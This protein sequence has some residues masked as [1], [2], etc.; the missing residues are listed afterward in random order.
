MRKNNRNHI[1]YYL[2]SF[3]VVLY[4]LH[5]TIT[6]AAPVEEA[7]PPIQRGLI[8]IESDGIDRELFREV[9]SYHGARP[10]KSDN[11]G[12]LKSAY[13]TTWSV[14]VPEKY[15]MD[16]PYGVIVYISSSDSGEIPHQW[17]P[18][19]DRHN[20]IW[21]GPNHAGNRVYPK[22]NTL[23][24]HALA[25][26]SLMQ[27]KERYHIDDERIY[28]SGRSGGG[29]IASYVAI[30]NSDLFSGGYY[31]VGCNPFRPIEVAAEVY[32]PGFKK[33]PTGTQLFR[34]LQDRYVMLTGSKDFNRE[35]TRAVYDFYLDE[36]FR[37][38]TYLD[39]PGMGH[40]QPPV[41]WFEKGII[42]LD[43]PLTI[44]TQKG[45]NQAVSMEER[46]QL[47][48]ALAGFKKATQCRV[49]D[50]E[51]IKLAEDKVAHLREE[52]AKAVIA[53]ELAIDSGDRSRAKSLLNKFKKS[54]KGV[55]EED[56]KRLTV[57]LTE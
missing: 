31:I 54:W 14:Y 50:D 53:I 57:R 25:L 6:D 18:I 19:F 20:L 52:Y 47:G 33:E 45:F 38:V 21:I 13:G 40:G 26:E 32:M 42:A 56:I 2:G 7:S 8:K 10:P 1:C 37:H 5:N 9:F 49:S 35:E 16:K 28:V 39:V 22:I 11:E 48:K 44:R 43:E 46:K 24:R 23:W 41:D 30:I 51:F 12:K 3:L 55:A 15:Q 17:M 4:C 34:A 27:I 36:N 29:R